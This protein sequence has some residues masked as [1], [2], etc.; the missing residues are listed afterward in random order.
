MSK[1]KAPKVRK[2]KIDMRFY[3]V[4]VNPKNK[5]TGD[6][7]VRAVCQA[8]NLP[9]KDVAKELFDEWMK[10]GYEMT[11]H[12]V[13]RKVLE[14][15]GFVEY[16]KPKK[17]NGKTYC[18]GEINQLIGD[19]AIALVQVANHYTV[20]KGENLID[21]WDCSAKSVYRY[22]VRKPTSRKELEVYGGV[23]KEDHIAKGGMVRL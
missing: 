16:G 15:H 7:A 23:I 4:N 22:F 12:R 3:L 1:I 8:T 17:D 11:D 5:K 6:C 2:G 9:Y 19:D 14:R 20:V 10:A 21:L 13:V 18:V